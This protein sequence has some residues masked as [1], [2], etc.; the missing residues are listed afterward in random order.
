MNIPGCYHVA[1]YLGNGL[2]THIGSSKF[3]KASKMKENKKLLGA[4]A[5]S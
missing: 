2:I 4:R 5:D 3:V 1:V